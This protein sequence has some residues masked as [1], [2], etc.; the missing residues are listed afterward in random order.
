MFAYTCTRPLKVRWGQGWV[1]KR[2]IGQRLEP[3]RLRPQLLYRK[4][5]IPSVLNSNLVFQGDIKVFLSM[6]EEGT[7]CI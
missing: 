2:G 7:Y 6:Q 4:L 5:R 3:K 1:G